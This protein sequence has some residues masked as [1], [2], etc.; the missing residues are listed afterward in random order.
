MQTRKSMQ[1]RTS[2]Y[3]KEIEEVPPVTFSDDIISH[4]SNASISG[5][6]KESTPM[7]KLISQKSTPQKLPMDAFMDRDAKTGSP[8]NETT[9][10]NTRNSNPD[11]PTESPSTTVTTSDGAS[12]PNSPKLISRIAGRKST[13]IP[14]SSLYKETDRIQNIESTSITFSDDIIS[15]RA[16][17]ATN[18]IPTSPREPP[19]AN[20]RASA[21]MNPFTTIY[22]EEDPFGIIGTSSSR[23]GSL[24]V[25]SS[26]EFARRSSTSASP[27]VTA[28][29]TKRVIEELVSTD[30]TPSEIESKKPVQQ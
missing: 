3:R 1:Q 21:I 9:N 28:K 19:K 13:A 17:S 2:L 8:R 11:T 23:R 27:T 16:M 6:P 14:R 12:A 22:K 24:D 7:R 20:R 5:S 15:E 25:F 18:S 29:P 10:G 26:T 30:D 4:F